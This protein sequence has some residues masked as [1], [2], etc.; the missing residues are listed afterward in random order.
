MSVLNVI[1]APVNQDM[2]AIL[3]T[4]SEP[5]SAGEVQ[6]AAAIFVALRYHVRVGIRT[7]SDLLERRFAEFAG[8]PYQ[9]PL[10][11]QQWE[12]LWET[13]AKKSGPFSRYAGCPMAGGDRAS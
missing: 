10:G 4:P 11:R 9:N 12:D 2:R 6:F 13:E 1:A 3:E 5:A 8:V 7:A